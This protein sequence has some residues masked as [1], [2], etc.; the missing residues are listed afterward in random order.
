MRFYFGIGS[1]IEP[2][3]DYLKMAS[4]ELSFHLT[5]LQFSSVYQT[6]PQDVFDQPSFLNAVI[7]GLSNKTARDWLKVIRSIEE[8]AQRRRIIPKGPRTLDIDILYCEGLFVND[9]DLTIPHGALHL[10][11][12]ALIPLLELSPDLVHPKDG[13]ALKTISMNLEDQG[14]RP[15]ASPESLLF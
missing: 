10:R 8:K 13:V 6:D 5:N 15:F 14:V 1:N 3:L 12:F 2:R 7:S 9:N 11:Q 4:R